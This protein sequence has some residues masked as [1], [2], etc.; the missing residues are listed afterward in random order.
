MTKS[1]KATILLLL[2]IGIISVTLMNP[3]AGNM[4]GQGYMMGKMIG[5]C[6][7]EECASMMDACPS[8]TTCT[9]M[10]PITGACPINETC[11]MMHP[12]TGAC[13][14]NKTCAVMQPVTKNCQA[15]KTCVV[16]QQTG[17]CPGGMTCM[18][19]EALTGACPSN[20]TCYDIEVQK[21]VQ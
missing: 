13:P 17:K 16:M 1:R 6:Q 18:T 8:D 19:L 21:P 11:V 7:S 10:H 14:P 12:I 15:N 20:S 5:Q 9:M 2:C 3:I 4:T